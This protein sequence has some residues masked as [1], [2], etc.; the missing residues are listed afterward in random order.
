MCL[1]GLSSDLCVSQRDFVSTVELRPEFLPKGRIVFDLAVT[2]NEV[3]VTL[4]EDVV[5]SRYGDVD[6]ILTVE[7]QALWR[8]VSEV[9]KLSAAD[10]SRGTLLTH[11][12]DSNHHRHFI[13]LRMLG[14][15]LRPTGRGV[16]PPARNRSNP[17]G[18]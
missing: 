6:A 16:S 14:L 13:W 8:T 1:Q 11:A 17:L 10:E 12:A 2:K 4:D 7:K 3:L 15:S 9:M 5:L 18:S